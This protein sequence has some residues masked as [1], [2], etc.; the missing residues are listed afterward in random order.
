MIWYVVIVLVFAIFLFWLTSRKKNL[1]KV[2]REMVAKQWDGVEEL[3]NQNRYKEAILEADKTFDFVLKRMNIKG[4][5]LGERLKNTKSFLKNYH[6][7]WEAHKIRNRL[8]HEVDFEVSTKQAKWAI[9]EF[10]KTIKSLN[11]L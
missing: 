5:T 1:N 2:D 10:K 8:V 9:E 7:T 4:A 6:N 11:V 3:F